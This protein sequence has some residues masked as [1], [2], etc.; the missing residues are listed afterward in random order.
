MTLINGIDTISIIEG[1][2][3]DKLDLDAMDC[4]LSLQAEISESSKT[5]KFEQRDDF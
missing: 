4:S 1:A 3:I 2:Q 5:I